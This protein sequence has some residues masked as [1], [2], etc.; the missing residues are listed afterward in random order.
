MGSDATIFLL[1]VF[2]HLEEQ[3]IKIKIPWCKGKN[4]AHTTFVMH[5]LSNDEKRKKLVFFT[6]IQT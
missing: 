2:I 3:K 4:S 1:D 5:H 6:C